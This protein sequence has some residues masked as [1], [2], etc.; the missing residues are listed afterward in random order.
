MSSK[1]KRQ[2]TATSSFSGDERDTMKLMARFGKAPLT[3]PQPVVMDN[4]PAFRL[5]QSPL[6]HVT[7]N[8]TAFHPSAIHKQIKKKISKHPITKLKPREQWFSRHIYSIDRHYIYFYPYE[9]SV[10]I[11]YVQICIMNMLTEDD[12][13][14]YLYN[15]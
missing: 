2:L 11:S 6:L 3:D 5:P 12:M 14:V 1:N 9:H 13:Y 8:V 4:L 10:V 15:N 7:H